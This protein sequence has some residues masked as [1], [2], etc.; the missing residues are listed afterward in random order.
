MKCMQL[1]SRQWKNKSLRQQ[2]PEI[3]QAN[4]LKLKCSD[5]N[6]CIIWEDEK[7]KHIGQPAELKLN[8]R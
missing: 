2:R 7:A 6:A 5:V 4:N 1:G 3:K 8:E